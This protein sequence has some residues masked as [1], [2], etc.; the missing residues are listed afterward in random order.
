[1]IQEDEFEEPEGLE[2]GLVT[3]FIFEKLRRCE[4]SCS[5]LILICHI[6]AA[7]DVIFSENFII[8]VFSMK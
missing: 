7:I 4:M 2:K 1:M 5:C 3:K 8:Y 6:C